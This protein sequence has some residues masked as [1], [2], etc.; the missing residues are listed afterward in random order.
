M[1]IPTVHVSLTHS[2]VPYLLTPGG[3]LAS[4]APDT[5]PALVTLLCFYTIAARHPVLGAGAGALARRHDPLLHQK[6][7]KSKARGD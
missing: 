4:L 5:P 6:S 1:F 7:R 3:V 2:H